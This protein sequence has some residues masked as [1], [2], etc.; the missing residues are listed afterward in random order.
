MVYKSG[1]IGSEAAKSIK[2]PTISMS[3]FAS[4]MAYLIQAGC[5]IEAGGS[6]TIV[7]IEAGGFY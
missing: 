4:C 3:F 5:L 6:D 7:V 1:Q 2:R